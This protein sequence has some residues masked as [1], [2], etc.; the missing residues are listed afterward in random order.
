[1]LYNSDVFRLFHIIIGNKAS[2]DIINNI[3]KYNDIMKIP[4]CDQ[5]KD[6]TNYPQYRQYNKSATIIGWC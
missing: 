4:D 5:S 6:I 1:M 3:N 2:D